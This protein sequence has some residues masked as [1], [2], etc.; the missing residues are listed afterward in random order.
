MKGVTW[1]QSTM[2]RL[3]REAQQLAHSGRRRR[4]GTTDIAYLKGPVRGMFFYLY[5]MACRK[6]VAFSV[7]EEESLP[8]TW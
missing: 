5:L 2:Y 4:I 7:H 8:Q 3:L 6:I 1:P